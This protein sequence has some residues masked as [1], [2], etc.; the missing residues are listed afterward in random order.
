MRAG[1]DGSGSTIDDGGA[2]FEA[3]DH[4]MPDRTNC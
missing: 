1:F 2:S 3:D 4:H